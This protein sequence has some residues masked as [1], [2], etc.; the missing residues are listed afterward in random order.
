[1]ADRRFVAFFG[2]LLRLLAAPAQRPHQLPE[3]GR[4]VPHA[5]LLLD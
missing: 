4:A 5:E 3:I 1:M 2:S